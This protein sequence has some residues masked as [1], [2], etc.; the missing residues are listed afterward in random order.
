MERRGGGGVGGG[1]N[2]SGLMVIGGNILIREETELLNKRK[3]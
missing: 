2:C 1:F 3:V